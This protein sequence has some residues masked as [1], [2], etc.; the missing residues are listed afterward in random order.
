MPAVADEEPYGELPAGGCRIPRKVRPAAFKP[1][2]DQS[3]AGVGQAP[4]VPKFLRPKRRAGI[5]CIDELKKR[6][7]T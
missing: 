6:T 5:P 4:A 3:N 7:T 2:V 1:K